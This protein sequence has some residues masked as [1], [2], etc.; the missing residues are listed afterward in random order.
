MPKTHNKASTR[1]P[2][3]AGETDDLAAL[4]DLATRSLIGQGVPRDPEDG[5]RRLRA[6]V[7]AGGGEAATRLAALSGVGAWTPQSWDDAL[8]WLE[9]GAIL[10]SRSARGQLSI[11]ARSCS[12]PPPDDTDWSSLRRGVDLSPWFTTPDRTVLCK[13]PKVRGSGRFV[14]PAVC[15]WLI[16]SVRGRVRPAKMYHADSKVEVFDP[17]R[18]CGDF[19]FDIFSADLILALLRARIS[20]ATGLPIAVMEPPRIFHYT[21]GQEIKP[22]YDRCND[23]FGGY[24]ADGVYQGDRIVT[25]LLYLNDDFDGGDLDF[26]KVGRRFKGR[27]GDAV[28]FA[29]VE[30]AGKP[31]PNS[32]HAGLPIGRGEKYVL[33][34]W[35]HDRA[36]V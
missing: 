36:L 2:G 3:A 7:E 1:A 13:S 10:G 12:Q 5:M 24:G 16:K 25:F 14:A 33:S 8:D 34:Q 11:L 26:P 17:H 27:T 21:Q 32:L 28:Y 29:H 4:T 6:A 35:I 18:T 15:D 30:V 23:G 9:R 31:D 19:E 22:H 20:A